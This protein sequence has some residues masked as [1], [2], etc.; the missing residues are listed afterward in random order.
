MKTVRSS[1]NF[2]LSL[3]RA[4]AP[5][6]ML[7][8]GLACLNAHGDIQSPADLAVSIGITSYNVPAAVAIIVAIIWTATRSGLGSLLLWKAEVVR[9]V[10]VV[11]FLAILAGAKR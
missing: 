1:L 10:F 3:S 9:S 7:L 4:G 11:L 5:V 6:W 2:D 8:L